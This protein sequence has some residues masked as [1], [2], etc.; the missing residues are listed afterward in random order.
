KILAKGGQLISEG[1][2]LLAT[3]ILNKLVFAQPQNRTARRL[4]ADAYEQLGYQAE[5]SSVRNSFLQGAYELRN[6]LPGGTPQKTTGPDVVRAMSTEMWLDFLGISVDPKKA[7]GMSFAINLVTPDNGEK[8]LVE[9]SNGTLT[10][11]K[12]QQAKNA[13]LTITLNRADLNRVMMG[14]SSFDDLINAGKAKFDGDRKPFD[15]LRSLLVSFS[16]NF[17]ILPG[18]APK[19]AAEGLP[20]FVLP[21]MTDGD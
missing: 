18:T 20:P 8:Y 17:E 19:A 9:L 21:D 5:S 12:G 6:G 11:I 7:E 2:Y 13:D 1:N 14:E 4:L 10:N 3:E 15:Q 16:P